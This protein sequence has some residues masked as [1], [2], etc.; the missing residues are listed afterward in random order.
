MEF[1]PD[2]LY[3]G[4]REGIHSRQTTTIKSLMLDSPRLEAEF[5]FPVLPG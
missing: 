5:S 1:K 2:V 3:E 4:R